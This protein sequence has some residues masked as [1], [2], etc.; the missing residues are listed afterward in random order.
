MEPKTQIRIGAIAALLVGIIPPLSS[1]T[2]LVLN[3][4][5]RDSRDVPYLVLAFLIVLLLLTCPNILFAFALIKRKV[6]IVK[7]LFVVLLIQYSWLIFN[8][9]VPSTV[10][11]PR[12]PGFLW[13]AFFLI[14]IGCLFLGLRGLKQLKTAE[15]EPAT[16]P[17][18]E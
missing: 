12:L 2:L 13:A 4:T 1:I 14:A 3:E 8:A 5:P 16:E 9:I 15:T 18:T 7:I 17:N 10:D 11:E 6:L